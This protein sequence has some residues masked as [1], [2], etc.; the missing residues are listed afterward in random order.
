MKAPVILDCTLRDGGYVTKWR[1][2]LDFVRQYLDAVRAD[3]VEIG[4]R[5]NVAGAG[6]FRRCTDAFID[7]LELREDMRVAVM[8]NLNEWDDDL[9][10][11]KGRID[12]VRVA[13]H[14]K[15]LYKAQ[16]GLARLRELGYTTTLNIMQAHNLKPK[17]LRALDFTGVCDAV[18]FADTFGTMNENAVSEITRAIPH[19][20]VGFHGHN[21]T[22]RAVVNTLAAVVAGASW[23]DGTLGGIGR[24]AG[25][26]DIAELRRHYGLSAG[27][28][29][30]IN[31]DALRGYKWGPNPV[32]YLGALLK[33]HPTK[34]QR[35]LCR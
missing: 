8:V 15:D 24:G 11:R 26:A 21:N 10:A 29:D 20:V 17:L 5:S 16:P 9:F 32:Y 18:Y 28:V 6:P 27:S 3:V 23:V 1:F 25:N 31:M 19:P 7:S 33:M 35:L 13:A 4:F 2:P 12:V 30:H 34:V 14:W 22:R